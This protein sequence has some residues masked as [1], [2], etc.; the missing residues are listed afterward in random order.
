MT[1]ILRLFLAFACG[2]FVGFIAAAVL[3]VGRK[4]DAEFDGGFAANNPPP[5]RTVIWGG[6]VDEDARR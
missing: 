4:A 3:S 6:G 1:D 2:G 5:V